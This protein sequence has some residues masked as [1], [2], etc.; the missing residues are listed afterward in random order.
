MLFSRVRNATKLP[1]MRPVR[2][3]TRFEKTISCYFSIFPVTQL[4]LHMY[5][6]DMMTSVFKQLLCV[7]NQK[8]WSR[9]NA[10]CCISLSFSLELTRK[11]VF[12]AMTHD[13][14]K[15]FVKGHRLLFHAGKLNEVILWERF[16]SCIENRKLVHQY[17]ITTY[18]TLR[19][20]KAYP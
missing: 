3:M 2:S 5:E 8:L 10:F 4:I 19:V 9:H 1:H 15:L 7:L 16:S 14:N 18:G 13:T 17:L 6:S 11:C 20:V 12:V